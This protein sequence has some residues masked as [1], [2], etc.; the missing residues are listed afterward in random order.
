MRFLYLLLFLSS[1]LFPLSSALAHAVA[2]NLDTFTEGKDLVVLM[3]GV[4]GEPING[5]TLA[6]SFLSDAGEIS[7]GTVKPIADGE[8]RVPVQIPSGTYTLK[9]RDTTFPQEAL[10][11]AAT[12][13]FPLKEP[14][15]LVL[16]PSKVGQPDITLL[17]IL[18]ALPVVIALIAL[19]LV[20]FTRPKNKEV[21]P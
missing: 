13:Q 15:R 20:L 11:V 5:A 4:Q 3:N 6:Y 10:E 19:A 7:S 16:P 9:F 14:V 2:V 18:A 8:Y 12:V 17:I 21:Q 1:F